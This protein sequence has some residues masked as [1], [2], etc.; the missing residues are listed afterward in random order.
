MESDL[1]AHHLQVVRALSR[2]GGPLSPDASTATLRNPA[3]FGQIDGEVAA[4]PGRRRL[5]DRL[6][7]AARDQVPQVE[8]GRRA[9][10]LAGP[11]GAGKSTVLNEVLGEDRGRFLVVDAD[12]FKRALLEEAVA[13]GSY[14]QWIKPDA[15]KERER[16]GERFF[17]L[18]LA[19]LVHEESS[20]LATRLR[21]EAIAEGANIVID[22][23]LSSPD[24]ADQLGRMLDRAGYAV[25]VIDV[26]VSYELSEERVAGRWR[27]SY[28]QALRTGDGLGGR[29]VPS[30]FARAVFEGP[31]GRSRPEVAAEA[32]AQGAP[33]VLRFRRFRTAV[34]GERRLEVDQGRAQVGGQL[35][36]YPLVK[37]ARTVQ[38]SRPSVVRQRPAGLGR[39]RGRD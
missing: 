14:E 34:D 7:A 33:N 4:T 18:E 23:V 21:R 37:T 27:Q 36:D 24:K 25:E 8:Q 15:V 30:E 26:E 22:T 29:W 9:I 10:V 31:Q 3:W 1:T 11:P 38:A 6:I 32:L 5:H 28:E 13:D 12:E 17:P 2:P 20:L 35:M 19:S 39:D 16:Q